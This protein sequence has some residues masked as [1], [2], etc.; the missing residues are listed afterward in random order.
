MQAG[1]A[2]RLLAFAICLATLGLIQ[3]QGTLSVA[4]STAVQPEPFVASPLPGVGKQTESCTGTAFGQ[5]PTSLAGC[6]RWAKSGPINVVLLSSGTENPYQDAIS[7]T[8]PRWRPADGGWLAARL[9]TRG[10]GSVWHT[11]EQQ[12]ELRISPRVRRHFKFIR[13]SCRWQGQAVTVGDAHTDV[14]DLKRCGGD[15]I[16]DLDLARD[17]LVRSLAAGGVVSRVEYRS[18]YA[19]GATFPDGCGQQVATDGR[20]AYVWLLD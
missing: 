12:A 5:S 10:C 8:K 17:D 11:S 13:P 7:E 15:H 20:V 4:A 19:P 16:S 3:G 18:W 14:Y 2:V 1:R 6:D 9:Q